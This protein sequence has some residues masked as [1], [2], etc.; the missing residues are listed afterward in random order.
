MAHLYGEVDRPEELRRLRELLGRLDGVLGVWDRVRVAGRPVVALD[1]GCGNTLQHPDNVGIDLFRCAATHVLAD[2]AR[3]LPFATSSVD[4]IFT[5]HVLEHLP[6]FLP[7]IDECHRVLRPGG[8]LHILAPWWRHVN[9]VADP[10]HLRL[11]DTQTIKGLCART[12]S[13]LRWHPL[14]AG[15]DGATVLADLTPLEP[16]DRSPSPQQ[17]ARFFD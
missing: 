11:F 6:D 5:V 10:T 12:G 3:P 4:R 9:A 8:V 7:L 16:G 13:P 17:M 14:L 1:L 2:V 15:C